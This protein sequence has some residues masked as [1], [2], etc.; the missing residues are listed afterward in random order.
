MTFTP[1]VK[2]TAIGTITPADSLAAGEYRIG[3]NDVR[4]TIPAAANQL[5][6]RV[7]TAAAD[8]AKNYE[9]DLNTWDGGAAVVDADGAVVDIDVL[10]ALVLYNAS[11]T[12]PVEFIGD[13][14]LGTFTG[15]LGA[16]SYIVLHSKAGFSLTTS[17][18]LSLEGIGGTA[19]VQVLLIGKSNA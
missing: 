16:E 14:T 15:T 17:S 18:V 2:L 8:T 13:A 10:Y 4:L 5:V 7:I 19:D 12:I 11:T 1:T 6:S 3:H 9:P